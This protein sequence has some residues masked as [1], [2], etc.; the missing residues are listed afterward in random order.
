MSGI[1][2]DKLF[3]TSDHPRHCLKE[4]RKSVLHLE[5]SLSLLPIDYHEPLTWSDLLA[6]SRDYQTNALIKKIHAI[7]KQIISD[8]HKAI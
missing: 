8:L 6:L 5:D 3:F 1:L 2:N 4:V 7:E